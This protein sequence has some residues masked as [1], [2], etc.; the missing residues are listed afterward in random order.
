LPVQAA[1]FGTSPGPQ[2][3]ITAMFLAVTPAFFA[4]GFA[5]RRTGTGCGGCQDDVFG[6]G[7][8]PARSAAHLR[9]RRI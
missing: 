5:G 2:T 3:G 6:G 4:P 7:A 1:V 9:H 8:A